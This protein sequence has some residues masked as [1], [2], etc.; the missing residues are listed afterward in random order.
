M[1]RVFLF[2][3]AVALASLDFFG[4]ARSVYAADVM[5]LEASIDGGLTWTPLASTNTYVVGTTTISTIGDVIVTS[6]IDPNAK[7]EISGQVSSNAPGTP[8]L[9]KVNN[10]NVDIMNLSTDGA[11]PTPNPVTSPTILIAFGSINFTAPTVKKTDPGSVEIDSTV[12]ASV[13][14]N[15]PANTAPD[16]LTF[17]SSVDQANGLAIAG[18]PGT[19]YT[20]LQSLD[21]TKNGSASTGDAET[22]VKPLAASFAV[23]GLL[24]IVLG[25]TVDIDTTTTTTLS[26]SDQ[27]SDFNP[28]PEPASMVL[29][30]LGSL[31][32]G[33]YSCKRRKLVVI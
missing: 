16:T 8:S 21:I 17:Q 23:N 10:T 24:T 11:S 13:S 20:S 5:L 7:V 19:Y 31:V 6:S 33:G 4:G 14:H 28:N 12:S 18:I 26:A 9:S 29:F 30:G 3:V 32:L 1:K 22:F 2:V 15:V 25:P 27:P